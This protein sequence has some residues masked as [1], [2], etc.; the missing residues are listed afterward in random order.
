MILLIQ[1]HA[2]AISRACACTHIHIHI[3]IQ[4]TQ[5]IPVVSTSLLPSIGFME[6]LHSSRSPNVFLPFI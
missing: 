5:Y 3:H 1:N 4:Y 2:I 6:I